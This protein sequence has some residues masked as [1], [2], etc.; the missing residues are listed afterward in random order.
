M[1]LLLLL[2]IAEKRRRYRCGRGRRRG[3]RLVGKHARA[4]LAHHGSNTT[5]VHAT[6]LLVCC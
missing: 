2:R 5:T 1:L 4:I 3:R 6:R